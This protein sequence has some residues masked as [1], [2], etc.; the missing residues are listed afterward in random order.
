MK[1]KKTKIEFN[2]RNIKR[3]CK[4]YLYVIKINNATTKV[5]L[6]IYMYIL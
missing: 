1:K 4:L 2:E 3:N 5:L 6:Y